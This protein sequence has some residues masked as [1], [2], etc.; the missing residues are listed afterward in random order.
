MANTL[1][2]V[3]DIAKAE[4]GYIEKRSNYNLDSKTA[5]AGSA[6][7]TKYGRDMHAL[8]PS[9][10]DFPAAWCDCFVDWCFQKA[11]G[12][13]NA[14]GLLGGDFNDYTPSSAQLYKNKNAWYKT[15]KIGDQIFFKND[16][17]ICHTGLV[18]DVDDTYVYTI[19]GN[20]SSSDGVVSN[21]GMVCKK[22]YKLTNSRIDG[23]GRPKYD[24]A[25]SSTALNKVTKWVGVVNA[26]SLNVRTWAGAENPKCSFGPL[27]KNVKVNVCDTINDSNGNAWYYISYNGKYGFVMAKY[28]AS[29]PSLKG[30]YVRTANLNLRK[31]AGTK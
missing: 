11:Y 17:R 12:T 24:V 8:Y 14:K 1:N 31:D 25:T 30:T 28:I 9:I 20:T 21:G 26:S 18:Y 6:N 19:E 2:K 15:P 10:M 16:T 3:L 7:Y 5:N 27:A 23:Y 13:S 29:A 22:K 4:V